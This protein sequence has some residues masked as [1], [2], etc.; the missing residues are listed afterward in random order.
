MSLLHD[1]TALLMT[2]PTNWCFIHE[3][4]TVVASMHGWG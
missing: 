1:E 4:F 2:G 3:E